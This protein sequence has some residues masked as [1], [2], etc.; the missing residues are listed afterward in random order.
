MPEEKT[1]LEGEGVLYSS[2]SGQL[3]E[4]EKHPVKKCCFGTIP[5]PARADVLYI[6]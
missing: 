3:V 5:V 2:T 6:V 4:S 1:R